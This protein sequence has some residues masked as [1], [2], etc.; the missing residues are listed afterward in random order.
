MTKPSIAQTFK[1]GDKLAGCYTL[2]ELL[3]PQGFW[4]VW[5]AQDEELNKDI[6]LHF[7]PD[8]VAADERA[9]TELKNEAKRNRQLIHPRIIRVHDLVQDEAW[10]AI[11]MD[12]IPGE[13]LAAL[14]KKREK[15]ALNPSELSTGIAE[16]C[17]TLE[18]AH[19][20]DLI[21]RDLA[22][23]NLVATANG[24]MVQ[25]FGISR[26]VLDSLARSGQQ[27][28]GSR[29]IAYI[30]PQQID[31][32]R[33]ARADDI[34]SLGATVYDL[35]TGAPPFT[36]GELVPQIRKT[37]PPLVS[38]RRAAL[39]IKEEVMPKAWDEAI[40]ACLAKNADDRPKTAAE[41]RTKFSAWKPGM[42]TTPTAKENTAPETAA[43]SKPEI[44][45]AAAAAAVV[46]GA[47]TAAAGEPPAGKP[48]A[49][50]TVEAAKPAPAEPES[51]PD[52]AKQ[53]KRPWTPA[54]GKAPLITE[55]TILSKTDVPKEKGEKS[56]AAAVKTPEPAGAAGSPKKGAPTTPTGFP[57]QAFVQVD[58]DAKKEKEKSPAG[59]IAFA[60]VLL[61]ILIVSWLVYRNNQAPNPP[62]ADTAAAVVSGTSSPSA[63]PEA[64]ASP[65]AVAAA[66]SPSSSPVNVAAN[67][68]PS[69]AATAA[70]SPPPSI[71]ESPAP[72]SQPAASPMP[73]AA[74]GSMTDA[75]A[76]Q[77]AAAK[78][79]AVH[80]AQAAFADAEKA[81]QQEAAAQAQAAAAVQ[82]L[83]AQSKQKADA[84]AAAKKS[85]DAA[86][87][88]LKQQQETLQKAEADAAE[89]QKLAAAKAAAADQVRKAIQAAQTTAMQEQAAQ[90]QAQTEADQLAKTIA[91]RQKA[92]DEAAKAA[93]DAAKARAQQAQALTQAQAEL[94]Q[95]QAQ[96]QQARAAEKAKA[97]AE[98]QAR[99]A[100]EEKAK[101]AA[102]QAAKIQKEHEEETARLA[103]QAAALKLQ[104]QREEETARLTAQA[105]AAAEAAANAQ[106]A[107]DA[108]KKAVAD[109][110][111][112]QQDAERQ[113]EAART[114]ALPLP[115]ATPAAS[116]AAV[117]PTATPPPAGASASPVSMEGAPTLT[118]HAPNP[119]SKVDQALMNSLG[120]RF[121]PVGKI[122]FSV[123]LTRV[124]DF[125]AFVEATGY[126][127]DAWR[128]PG[129]RQ[130]DD[131]P[132]VNVSWNDANQFCLW[133]T[134]KEHHAGIL[135]ANQTYRLPT[136]LEWSAAA[137]LPTEKGSTPSDR[138][139]DVPDVYPWGTQ[140]PPP[141]GA[142]NYT[143][144]ETDSDV[145]IKGYNDGFAWT[146]PVG[147]FNPNKYGLYD[148][149]G[150][151]WEWCADWWDPSNQKKVLRGASWDNGALK[152]SLLSS[153]RERASAD[154]RA[155]D[156]GFRVVIAAEGGARTRKRR[157]QQ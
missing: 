120:M 109:A 93:A 147:S 79:K 127:G 151:V 62:P 54:P 95:V 47:A 122:F 64:S 150:N 6:V 55:A 157:P 50:P 39:E 81:A 52:L 56:E 133:L 15:N 111:K 43:T 35:L 94:A 44:A 71:A 100:A 75:Q 142:G 2:K 27:P 11:S 131:H 48:K 41:A 51:K 34:Y 155:D 152:L 23:E 103:A 38:E 31:G 92:A 60:V 42:P 110:E 82:A 25:K 26:V 106:K 69:P 132:V 117:A 108:A 156:F 3:P 123:W 143:G 63:S 7:V 13:T 18:D 139:M 119:H 96:V 121:A 118:V 154:L 140:W 73:A 10:A 134:Q 45:A 153:C 5:L 29:D 137:G 126:Q 107:L 68:A 104:K 30:G 58:G 80:D 87:A 145:A 115:S 141:P 65:T 128:D 78:A 32:E 61:L 49:E 70:G 148:M 14:Q 114:G 113:A 37:V 66:T 28:E 46:A 146:S 83:Q 74:L 22:P 77:L 16:L 101:A 136:D 72:S 19:R 59:L 85:A 97:A 88:A 8:S 89:A 1:A 12:Y 21:H 76:D 40:A 124:K 135:A 24:V 105:A 90:A 57:L 116:P 138:D 129:F 67:A 149:G 9:M 17:Q 86:A 4:V 98:E 144:E 53:Q 33:P 91:D 125:Q 20:I 130:G 84:A 99:I 112:A 102:E 36:E